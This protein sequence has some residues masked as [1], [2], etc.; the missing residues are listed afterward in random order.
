M[1]NLYFL[2]K[3]YLIFSLKTGGTDYLFFASF[4]P[5][6]AFYQFLEVELKKNHPRNIAP[7]PQKLKGRS[8]T[9]QVVSPTA[10]TLGVL[11]QSTIFSYSYNIIDDGNGGSILLRIIV[12]MVMRNKYIYIYIYSNCDIIDSSF[13]KFHS[14]T[15]SILVLTYMHILGAPQRFL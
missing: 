8:L 15:V 9:D 12:M 11:K 4:R 5:I 1:K 6:F 13:I 7:H 3:I 10:Y 2:F 14:R